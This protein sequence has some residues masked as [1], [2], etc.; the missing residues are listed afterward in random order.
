MEAEL[1][2]H[3]QAMHDA[4]AADCTPCPGD[5]GTTLIQKDALRLRCEQVRVAF[6]RACHSIVAPAPSL[7][8]AEVGDC[9][10]QWMDMPPVS[11]DMNAAWD[12]LAARPFG[13][14]RIVICA[15]DTMY[16]YLMA[17]RLP[18]IS[19]EQRW[20]NAYAIG[21]HFGW[22]DDDTDSYYGEIPMRPS[23]QVALRCALEQ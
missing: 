16:D 7:S 1:R 9:M 14:E 20:A 3:I 21:A 10:M 15:M 22:C 23:T 11:D 18:T 12:E 2:A 5:D 4:L 19:E 6:E 13:N 8:T 17:K